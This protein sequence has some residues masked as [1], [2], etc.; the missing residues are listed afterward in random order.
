MAT[1]EEDEM[2]L[3]AGDGSFDGD[4]KDE[5]TSGEGLGIDVGD[6]EKE[7]QAEI[8]VPDVIQ[9]EEAP[10]QPQ[11]EEEDRH[12]DPGTSFHAR[13]RQN[14]SPSRSSRGTSGSRE[15]SIP[16]PTF[17]PLHRSPQ[18]AAA[19]T[20]KTTSSPKEVSSLSPSLIRDPSPRPLA[21]ATPL[22]ARLSQTSSTSSS[23]PLNT[24]PLSS[25]SAH[26]ALH[27]PFPSHLAQQPMQTPAPP[28]TPYTF[29][30]A[31]TPESYSGSEADREERLDREAEAG[32]M[33]MSDDFWN[34][35][36]QDGELGGMVGSDVEEQQDWGR[37]MR[38]SLSP[39]SEDDDEDT[40]REMDDGEGLDA[41]EENFVGSGEEAKVA[42]VSLDDVL[43]EDTYED[44]EEEVSGGD[45]G[46]AMANDLFNVSTDV[47]MMDNSTDAS[48][49]ERPSLERP[50][51]DQALLDRPS[52]DQPSIDQ[53][54]LDQP[55]FDNI[56]L[57]Q[58]SL[59]VDEPSLD[60][61]KAE[62]YQP[63]HPSPAPHLFPS[64]SDVLLS[65]D[66]PEP[67][68]SRSL[69][70]AP[71]PSVRLSFTVSPF[72]SHH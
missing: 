9:E 5:E 68:P 56:T 62:E 14:D 39:D 47:S 1:E 42:G 4:V 66:R 49:G 2:A 22:V 19:N 44:E 6:A 29:A 18:P 65:P 11:Q 60:P 41:V 30:K 50:S 55:A 7:M 51:L 61:S 17:H 64:S 40:G 54:A 16:P 48:M 63:S 21:A 69:A 52:L 10:E 26:K 36:M 38:S 35:E 59:D 12:Q 34:G 20:R 71:L 58:P 45:G 28:M 57:D 3:H 23:T 13:H 15:R 8:S 53:S 32:Q 43:R 25:T 24:V 70:D 46:E 33:T 31:P 27:N 67:S 37:R 72:F